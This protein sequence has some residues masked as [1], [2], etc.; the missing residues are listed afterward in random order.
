MLASSVTPALFGRVSTVLTQHADLGVMLARM[1]KQFAD[2]GGPGAPNAQ[3]REP[4]EEFAREL[5]IHFGVEENDEYFGTIGADQPA[6]KAEVL[7]LLSEH[8]SLAQ[9]VDALLAIAAEPARHGELA[10]MLAG[11]AE[12]LRAHERA[13]TR[14]LR[15]YFGFR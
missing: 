15:E 6:L 3:P 14:L 11:F 8:E 5:R 1:E 2:L 9:A 10:S 12:K 13:E 4:L 7:R